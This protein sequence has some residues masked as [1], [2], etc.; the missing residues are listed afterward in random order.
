MHQENELKEVNN[1]GFTKGVLTVFA[2]IL[3]IFSSG[4]CSS[5][6]SFVLLFCGTVSICW[7]QQRAKIRILLQAV[8]DVHLPLVSIILLRTPKFYSSIKLGTAKIVSIPFIIYNITVF[9]YGMYGATYLINLDEMVVLQWAF[10][11]FFYWAAFNI[12][13]LQ[14]QY[15]WRWVPSP[16]LANLGFMLISFGP[17]LR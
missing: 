12:Y 3:S 15:A 8:Q 16:F 17:I 13:I 10:S 5:L 14:N 7:L 9:G 11:G 2:K 1:N 4:L 6:C